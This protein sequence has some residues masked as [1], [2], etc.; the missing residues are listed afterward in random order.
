[1]K[2]FLLFAASPRFGKG[3]HRYCVRLPLVATKIPCAQLA[4]P[5]GFSL[6]SGL[7]PTY[8]HNRAI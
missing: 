5:V 1:M 3:L 7:C 6:L 2:L 4:K 8:S